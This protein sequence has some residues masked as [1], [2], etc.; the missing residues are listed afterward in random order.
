M[1][2]HG[3]NQIP[4]PNIDSLAYSGVILNNYYV[5]PICT[6]SRSALMSG[7]HPIHTG[8]QW[9]DP[10]QYILPEGNFEI[11]LPMKKIFSLLEYTLKEKLSK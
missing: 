5:D 10:A 2:F 6:P 8:R 9:I 4:T 1:S 7:R 3:S 11:N